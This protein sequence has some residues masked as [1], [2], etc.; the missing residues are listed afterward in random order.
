MTTV[1]VNSAV[2]LK[3]YRTI[4]KLTDSWKTKTKEEEEEE[5]EEITIVIECITMDDM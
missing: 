4:I 1:V 3:W 2:V 5:E